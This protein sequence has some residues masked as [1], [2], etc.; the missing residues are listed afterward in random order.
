MMQ[1]HISPHPKW[2]LAHKQPGSEIR[3]LKGHYYLYEI[4]S[5]WSAEKKR[6][7]KITGKLLGKITQEDGFVE[8]EKARLRKQQLKVE[9]VEVKEYG[10]STVIETQFHDTISELKKQFPDLWQTILCLAYGRLVYQSPLKNMSFRYAHSYLS[11]LYPKLDLSP[12][13]LSSSLKKIGCEREKIV[14]FCKS[15]NLS[16]DNILFDGTDIL[17]HSDK[18]EFSKYS[19]VKS[20]CYDDMI[21][22][23]CVFSVGQQ[24]P[25]YYRLLPGNIK[26]VSAFKTSLLESG[27]KEATVVMDKGFTSQGNVEVLEKAE[28]KF[29]IPLHRNSSQ[30]NY[31]KIRDGNKRGFDGYFKYEGRYIWY[32][33][34]S[35]DDSKKLTVFFDEELRTREERDYL[36]R[37]DN[38]VADYTIDNFHEK[39]YV[40]GTIAMID[41]TGRSAE[42][43]YSDYKTR[44]EVE[45]MIDA[46][47]NVVEADRSY[48]QNQQA[49][50]GWMFINFIALKWYYVILNL[51]KKHDINKQYATMDFLMMLGEIKKVKIN[52]SWI[53]AE[54]TR[55]TKEMLKLVGITHIT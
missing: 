6:A 38:K 13:T 19:R 1:T 39:Q 32:Y 25:L 15:F 35:V 30:I 17:S 14:N 37:I 12:K 20:G 42:K 40:L 2:V 10:I 4:S 24:M 50:E 33:A 3:F 52:S 47:K 55:K 44:G 7:V 53:N 45:T 29:I 26:D 5:K 31:D 22:L 28:L 23:M 34:H 9:R 54:I 46:L 8:S 11:E 16:G 18:L 43:I 41:N 36:S 21:N 49:L 48:M 27:I 51:L